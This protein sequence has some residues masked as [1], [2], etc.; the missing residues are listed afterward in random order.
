MRRTTPTR[1]IP[2]F[3]FIFLVIYAPVHS[4]NYGTI[5]GFAFDGKSQEPLIGVNVV[6]QRTVLGASTDRNGRFTIERIPAGTYSLKVSTMGY[7][8]RTVD[9]VIVRSG[10][11]THLNISLEETVIALNP[12]V[13]TA[14][15]HPQSLST[16]H[17][18]VAVI[19]RSSI[20]RRQSRDLEEALFTVSGVHF[21]EQNISIRG[22]SGFS[23]YNV[24]S[25][26]LLMID[27]VPYLTS[28]LGAI[29]W[30]TL[31]LLDV[32]RIEVV[33]GAGSALYG[34]SAM[35]GVVNILTRTPSPKG[36]L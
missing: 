14:A 20:A 31:P 19:H 23:V 13:V 7:K 9:N 3:L 12:I 34:S 18:V 30:E 1:N 17:Q 5:T 36:H 15:K 27:G 21:N 8:T 29:N 4:Q 22:S 2:L 6:V 33:K 16:S 32:D 10:K 28:D 25:R 11:T 35:G 26:V 24:G